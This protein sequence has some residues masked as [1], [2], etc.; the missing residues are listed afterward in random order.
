MTPKRVTDATPPD[1]TC[2]RTL[3]YICLKSY[4]IR[5]STCCRRCQILHY[6]LRSTVQV[7]THIS[8]SRPD[9]PHANLARL[10][11]NSQRLTVRRKRNPRN[12]TQRRT[13]RRPILV[14]SAARQMDNPQ[15]ILLPPA[16]HDQHLPVWRK[17]KMRRRSGELVEGASRFRLLGH[18]LLLVERTVCRRWVREPRSSVVDVDDSA[19]AADCDPAVCA[20]A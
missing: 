20:D 5:L 18:R 19:G 13:A 3:I 11:S 12:P 2:T 9:L 14:H 7:H 6:I 1:Q 15:R 4:Y 8:T 16:S 10:I 17:D